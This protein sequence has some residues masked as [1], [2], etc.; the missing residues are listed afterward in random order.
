MNSKM[1]SYLLRLSA[2][3]MIFTLA[4]LSTKTLALDNNYASN[5]VSPII[6]EDNFLAKMAGTVIGFILSLIIG[7]LWIITRLLM[8]VF[9]FMGGIIFGFFIN[10]PL[11]TELAYIRPLWSFLVDFGNLVVIGSFIA[12]ALVYLFDID[13]PVSKEIGKFAGGV[14]MVALLLNFSLTMTSAFAST[15]HSIGIGT[16]YATQKQVGVNIDF[17]SRSGFNRSIQNTGTK[18]FESTSNNFVENVSCLG[19]SKVT[20]KNTAEGASKELSMPEVCGFHNKVDGQ[21]NPITLIG[22]SSGTS[23]AFRF[24]LTA[25]IRE[26]IVIILLGMGIMVLIKLLYVAIFRLAY[27]WLVGIFAGPALVAAFSPFAGIKKYF[28]TWLRLLVVFSTMMIVFVAGF[29]LS[30]Y[31]GTINLPNVGIAKDIDLD[32]LSSPGEYVNQLVNSM[33]E[34]VVPTIMFPIIG[35]AILYLL[36]KYLDETYQQHV[37]KALKAGGKMVSDARSSVESAARRPGRALG[38]AIGAGAGGLKNIAN[39]P[40]AALSM[41]NST[42]SKFN[43]GLAA[44]QRLFGK[45]SAAKITDAKAIKYA[46]KNAVNKQIMANRNDAVSNFMSGKDF[47]SKLAETEYLAKQNNSEVLSRLGANTGAFAAEAKKAG[48]SENVIRQGQT[49]AYNLKNQT[50][51]TG[52][53]LKQRAKKIEKRMA[54]ESNKNFDSEFNEAKSKLIYDA[55]DQEQKAKNT[56]ERNLAE[57]KRKTLNERNDIQNRTSDVNGSSTLSDTDKQKALL[58]L[59]TR[60]AN[61][62]SQEASLKKQQDD[63]LGDIAKLRVEINKV[64]EDNTVVTDVINQ[65]FLS[66]NSNVKD[67]VAKEID[68]IESRGIND[69]TAILGRNQ[70]AN[71]EYE[72]LESQAN[73]IFQ[74]MLAIDKNTELSSNEKKTRKENLMGTIAGNK[75]EVKKIAERKYKANNGN[76]YGDE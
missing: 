27:L 45:E 76:M 13:I 64:A 66:E 68:K 38:S 35:L 52:M 63:T 58:A 10:N 20:F 34:I 8:F 6:A 11:D 1:R 24:Y 41:K 62:D 17:T 71:N 57:L 12:L 3:I 73:A 55:I 33:V 4:F 36:G 47:K 26:I 61:L 28:S 9:R 15:V 32:P 65:R 53:S 54:M 22:A 59:K 70:Q 29:Y 43:S 40:S 60:T 7:L 48:A 5:L 30:S 49:A 18:F 2:I 44:G 14:V 19:N 56:Y 23:E 50:V 25:I 42:F 72:Q 51:G 69:S 74:Q 31:I 46:G 67:K 37:E 75:Q 21:L 39:S 16:I